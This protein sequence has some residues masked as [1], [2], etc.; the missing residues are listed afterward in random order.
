[1]DKGHLLLEATRRLNVLDELRVPYEI[2]PAA[3]SGP[4]QRLGPAGRPGL[5]WY[6]SQD[7]GE[8]PFHVG[9][10][11]VWAAS[12]LRP[13]WRVTQPPSALAGAQPSL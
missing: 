13:P 11:P 12:L 5:H 10:I 1:M 9:G 8:A 2:R 7:G 3:D 6:R 4:W